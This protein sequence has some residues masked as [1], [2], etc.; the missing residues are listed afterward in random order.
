MCCNVYIEN[1]T[2]IY[3]ARQLAEL[4]GRENIL[5]CAADDNDPPT[6]EPVDMAGNDLAW[7]LCPV[8]I[9]ATMERAGYAVTFDG[10]DYIAHK[11][12]S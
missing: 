3:Q 2:G 4:I 12:R 7:C 8:D 5:W 10:C 1:R 9:E 6:P 11:E